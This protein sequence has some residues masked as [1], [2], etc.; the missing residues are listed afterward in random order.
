MTMAMSILLFHLAQQARVTSFQFSKLYSI[1]PW[2]SSL[3]LYFNINFRQGLLFEGTLTA[4]K[5]IKTNKTDIIYIFLYGYICLFMYN[6]VH[7]WELLMTDIDISYV[8]VYLYIY[9]Y[10]HI[11]IIY[12]YIYI[13]IYLYVCVGASVCV[14]M[15]V[16]VLLIVYLLTIYTI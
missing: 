11:Y 12:I 10:I 5:L 2:I 9:I 6:I 7:E 15:Y 1:F 14:C 8:C 16:C 13:Y 3:S 4:R